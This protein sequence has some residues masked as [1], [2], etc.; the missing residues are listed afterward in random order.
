MDRTRPIYTEDLHKKVI[1]R[2]E[3]LIAL[4]KKIWPDHAAKFIMPIVRYD[5]KGRVGGTAQCPPGGK[6]ILRFNLIMCYE[7]EEHFIKQIVGHEWAHVVQRMIHG[8]TKKVKDKHGVEIT[9]KVMPHGQEWFSVMKELDLELAKYHPYQM[10][11]IHSSP[12]KSRNALENALMTG[13]RIKNIKSNFE[14]LPEDVRQEM[15]EWALN[16]QESSDEE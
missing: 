9:K 5:L 10:K 6:P 12:R 11:S 15:I 4:S 8:Q 7:N 16:F 14:K 1:S 2:L 3:E 13:R